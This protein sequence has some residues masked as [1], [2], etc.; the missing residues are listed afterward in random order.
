M[1]LTEKNKG[2]SQNGQTRSYCVL[3]RPVFEWNQLVL[4]PVLTS[5][6]SFLFADGAHRKKPHSPTHPKF[7]GKICVPAKHEFCV[8]MISNNVHSTDTLHDFL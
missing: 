5:W 1:L 8:Q 6:W 2:V 7:S 4:H 3:D